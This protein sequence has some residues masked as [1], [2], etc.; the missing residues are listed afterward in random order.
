MTTATLQQKLGKCPS[1]GVKE[2]R[3]WFGKAAVEWDKM[4]TSGINPYEAGNLVG[5]T[6][7][8]VESWIR[9][10]STGRAYRSRRR[11]E[12]ARLPEPVM[13]IDQLWREYL[14]SEKGS[15][16]AMDLIGQ[17]KRSG[18]SL[19]SVEEMIEDEE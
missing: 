19:P 1:T 6:K 17:I 11:A 2:R 7:Y 10:R 15:Q 16:R 8:R 14:D 12:P 4:V 9:E 3:K 13:S 5:V 18:P